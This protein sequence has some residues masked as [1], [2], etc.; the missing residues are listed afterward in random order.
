MS[1]ACNSHRSFLRFVG[2][3]LA[4]ALVGGSSCQDNSEKPKRADDKLAHSPHYHP[5]ISHGAAS[6]PTSQPDLP[7]PEGD[8]FSGQRPIGSPVMFVNADTVTVSDILEP[9]IDELSKQS[10]ALNEKDYRESVLRMVRNQI[11]YQTG[12]T[13]VYQE[14][15][16][17]YGDKKFQEV[18]D[19][20]ADEL[21][22]ELIANRYGGVKARFEAHLKSLD[23]K[24]ADIKERLKRE[25]MIREYFRERFKPMLNEPS[26]RELMRY[27]QE[28]LAELTTP[29]KAELLLIEV[30]IA[31]ETEKPL[32]LASAEEKAQA[33]QKALARCA[34]AREEL[35]S[36]VDFASVARGYSKGPHAEQGG[37]W[38]EISPGALT[39][40]W[41]KASDVLFTLKEGQISEII[42]AE[43]AFFVVKC[44]KYTP[45]HQASFEEAQ[46]KMMENLVEEQFNTLRNNYVAELH[47]KANIRNRPEF[48]LAVLS[49]SPRPPQK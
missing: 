42:D 37:S 32:S 41:A 19:K 46:R 7:D 49:A 33:R 12:V 24:A 43:D 29:P 39:K 22:K 20:R 17:P 47:Q 4:A 26:R 1:L 18:F 38:G 44:G 3:M 16:K 36:G 14:A 11:D 34:R 25:T 9:I 10:A 30:P 6:R 21:V 45:A 35:E 15:K 2:V 28:H 8:I 31:S 13:L 40:R 27:Y 23:L 5:D 48:F